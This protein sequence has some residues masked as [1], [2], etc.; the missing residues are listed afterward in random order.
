MVVGAENSKVRNAEVSEL[1]NYGFANY[2]SKNVVAAGE[3]VE[4][5]V[6]VSKGKQDAVRGV[7]ESDVS[8]FGK[9]GSLQNVEKEAELY[10]LSAPISKGD[11][12]GELRVKLN[13][14]IVGS[15]YIL[16]DADVTT[17]NYRDF[18]NDIVEK[19]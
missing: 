16:S 1:L 14:E 8:I 17:K 11:R 5:S 12:I 2:E 13:G 15:T 7:A 19:W 10:D 4:E 3:V 6:A 18:V 9:K